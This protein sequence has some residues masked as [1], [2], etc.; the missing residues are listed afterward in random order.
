MTIVGEGSPSARPRLAFVSFLSF[1]QTPLVANMAPVQ[2]EYDSSDDEYTCIECNHDRD[3]YSPS[4]F[5]H[6][7]DLVDHFERA[8]WYCHREFTLWR[9]SLSL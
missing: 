3:N 9:V 7:E 6:K 5:D 2:W 4:R 8:H 1:T